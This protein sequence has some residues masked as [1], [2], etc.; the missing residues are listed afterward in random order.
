MDLIK[1]KDKTGLYRDEQTNAIVNM[2]ESEYE[3]YIESYKKSYSD[4]QKIKN[5]EDD[6]AT[7]RNDLSEIKQLLRNLS[8]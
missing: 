2:N 1:V 8:K 5:L 7:I 6:V 4:K 3:H